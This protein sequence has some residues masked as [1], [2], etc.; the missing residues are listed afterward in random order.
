MHELITRHNILLSL[1]SN[2]LVQC[3]NKNILVFPLI[4]I[5]IGEILPF[6][7]IITIS[8]ISIFL[9][10]PSFSFHFFSITRKHRLGCDAALVVLVACHT[11]VT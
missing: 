10:F 7:E 8:N 2:L 9:H 1:S 11:D 3:S 5:N 6:E 4:Y